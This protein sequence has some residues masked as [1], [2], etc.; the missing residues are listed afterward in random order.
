MRPS[1]SASCDSGG[2]ITVA[3][4]SIFFGSVDAGTTSAAIAAV[5]TNTG[6]APFGPINM[7]GGA[8][9]TGEFGASQNCQ[10]TTLPAGGSCQITYTFSPT[11]AGQVT[12]CS[13]FTISPASSQTDG[14]DFTITL[15]GGT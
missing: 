3:P 9:P 13:S 1:A 12:D 2:P 6:S 14:F 4:T 10:A 15:S 11:A 8:P 5:V 7:F